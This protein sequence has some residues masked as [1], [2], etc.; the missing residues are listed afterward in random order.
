M[1]LDEI[2]G[3]ILLRAGGGGGMHFKTGSFSLSPIF[4][5]DC[6]LS[7]LLF[8]VEAPIKMEERRVKLVGN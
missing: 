8:E 4:S 3:S 7:F 2:G 6:V 1:F 5:G